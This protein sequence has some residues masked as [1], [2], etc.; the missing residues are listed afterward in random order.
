ATLIRLGGHFAGGT[1][2]HWADTED[3]AGA[4]LSGDIVQVASE[5]Y[6][7]VW[8]TEAIRRRGDRGSR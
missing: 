6:S 4:L 3:R 5:S 7:G 2:L 1:V 8:V